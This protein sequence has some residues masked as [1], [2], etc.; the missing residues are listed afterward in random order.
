MG[1]RCGG[2]WRLLGGKM[3]EQCKAAIITAEAGIARGNSQGRKLRRAATGP[4]PISG[5]AKQISQSPAPWIRIASTRLPRGR[6]KARLRRSE[7]DRRRYFP[8]V[9]NAILKGSGI[10]RSQSP[11]VRSPFRAVDVNGWG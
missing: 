5:G 8:F 6:A 9:T 10:T 7:S 4:H 1:Q 2:Q 3:S 11:T